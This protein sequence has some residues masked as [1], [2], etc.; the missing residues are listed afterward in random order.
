MISWAIRRKFLI[1]S[2]VSLI[3]IAGAYGGYVFLLKQPPTCFD[4]KQNGNE[5]GTDCGGACSRLC[6]EEIKNPIM[7]WDPRVFKISEDNYSV[8]VYFENP[9]ASASVKNASYTI[10][11]LGQ[12]NAV[13]SE[14]KGTISIPKH[15]QFAILESNFSF[16]NKEPLKADFFWDSNLVWERDE[17]SPPSIFV[18]SRELLNTETKPRINAIVLNNSLVNIPALE[19]IAVVS[20]GAGNAIGASKTLL[21]DLAKGATYPI[22][23][24]WPEPFKTTADI[25]ENQVDAVLLID[26]SGSIENF[27]PDVKHAAEDFLSF[28][29]TDDKV[30]VISFANIPS[31]PVDFPISLDKNSAKTAIENITILKGDTQNTN[32]TDT[33][34]KVRGML[35]S[36]TVKDRK[37]VVV[38]LTDGVPTLPTK[39]GVSTYP[40]ITAQ[41]EAGKIKDLKATIFTIGLG[42][43]IDA[44]FLKSISTNKESY[45]SAPP[46]STLGD[47]YKTIATQ[48]CAKKPAQINI[49]PRI[50]ESAGL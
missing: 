3:I 22:T 26:R 15:T 30:G 43:K 17:S 45:F 9:N 40:Q 41:E 47:I 21:K 6:I 27:L 28:L 20:D 48:V 8:L 31:E 19:L 42:D 7:R 38:L 32:I 4:G 50:V 12:K 23:F 35:E 25:C 10:K 5:I 11:V 13:L 24:S 46:S 1:V 44:E 49:I 16:S 33:L 36:S 29:K 18:E 2:I 37:Q 39:K 34:I 14:R